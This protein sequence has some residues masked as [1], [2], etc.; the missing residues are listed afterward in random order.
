MIAMRGRSSKLIRV[1]SISAAR[2]SCLFFSYSLQMGRVQQGFDFWDFFPAAGAE[3]LIILFICSLA[4][5]SCMLRRGALGLAPNPGAI[6]ILNMAF[7]A[8]FGMSDVTLW[9]N[10]A[11]DP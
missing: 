4:E 2:A 7:V 3:I 10:P 9:F 6:T 5:G 1:V 8:L 11:R